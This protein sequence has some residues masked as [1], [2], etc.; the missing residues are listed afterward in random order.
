MGLG[1]I[2]ICDIKESFRSAGWINTSQIAAVNDEEE[3]EGSNFVWPC[4]SDAPLNNWETL[5]LLVM[6][7]LVKI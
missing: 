4:V 5:D 2:C 7:N 1:K 6:F 3:L